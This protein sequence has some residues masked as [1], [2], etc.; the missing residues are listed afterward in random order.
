M[1]AFE[2]QSALET[3]QTIIGH[4]PTEKLASGF[5]GVTLMNINALW[6]PTLM[7]HRWKD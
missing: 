4:V 2:I 6:H 7:Y 3:L 1:K 5:L